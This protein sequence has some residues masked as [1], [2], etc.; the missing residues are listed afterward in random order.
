MDWQTTPEDSVPSTLV[1]GTELGTLGK[2]PVTGAWRPGDHPGARHFESLGEQWVRGGRLP[3]VRVAYETW[4]TL[5]AARD[6]AVL[7]LHALTGDSHVTGAAGPG[8]RTAGWWGDVVG[9]GRAIDTDRW[10]VI[11]PNMLGGCQGTTG[12]SSV[13]PSGAEW[14]SRF[15]FVTVRDQVEVQAQLAD[16]LGIDAFAAVVGGS[17]GGMHA[18]EF[19][20]SHPARVRRLA[21]LASTAQTTADQIAANSLQRAAIQMD[22]AFAGGDYFEAEAGEGP[23]RGLSLAR[24][25]ALMTYRA[26]DELNSRFARSWQSD[27]SP[28]GDDGRFSVES[29]L[30]F[31]GNKFTRRFDASSYV[32]LT[33]AMDSHDVGAGRGGVSA[34]LGLVTAR[35]LVVGISSDRLFPVED[36][37][38]IAAGV[39]DALDGDSAA[40]IESEFGHDG[41]LIE[42][43][44]VGAHLRRLLES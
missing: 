5:N 35:T 14:G 10:F 40:V 7:V 41:F 9:P 28:L 26:S 21:V 20:V 6:N 17:M 8:H 38:R 3:S 12:P 24:R 37:H 15:P 22:P 36:Q 34:A 31:H 11:A 44:Q 32:T 27:V 29:Y 2:P 42:H 19:A 25:M 33:Y 18:L 16:R 4:G 30:D 23:H 39:P 13:S 1:P 43:E